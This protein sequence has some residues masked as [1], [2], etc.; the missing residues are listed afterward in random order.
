MLALKSTRLSQGGAREIDW[1]NPITKDL[2]FVGVGGNSVY[3]ALPFVI[4]PSAAIVASGVG[5]ALAVTS[6]TSVPSRLIAPVTS[7]RWTLFSVASNSI[8]SGFTVIWGITSSKT[9]NRIHQHFRVFG[10]GRYGVDARPY[11]VD[12]NPRP[13]GMFLAA[14]GDVAT[15]VVISGP[16]N[17]LALYMKGD[18]VDSSTLSSTDA[19]S[20]DGVQLF[21]K[22]GLSDPA[23]AG[24]S[25]SASMAFSRDL[26]QDEIRSLS[27]NPWQIFR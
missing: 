5:Q 16:R 26:S 13:P 10:S 17:A 21:A 1:G 3:G 18:M 11:K 22:Q 27:A 25:I 12:Y 14:D 19:V 9:G 23:L 6:P 20:L 15:A 2:F 24:S 8:D 7:N 4:T